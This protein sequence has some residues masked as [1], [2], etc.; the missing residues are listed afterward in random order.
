L[1][2]R[3][4]TV[5]AVALGAA[6]PGGGGRVPLGVDH[7]V[8][9][10]RCL[11]GAEEARGADERREEHGAGG[12][13]A[14]GAGHGARAREEQSTNGGV[15]SSERTP[16]DTAAVPRRNGR[17]GSLHHPSSLSGIAFKPSRSPSPRCAERSE[18]P[19]PPAQMARKG[20]WG[21]TS[22]GG[23]VV[24]ARIYTVDKGRGKQ[25]RLAFLHGCLIDASA[26]LWPSGI[27][28]VFSL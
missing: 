6:V 1:S 5:A 9:R 8:R 20:Q 14:R 24:A 3:G 7:P 23:R 18:L 26:P 13:R 25:E 11:P 16:T 10:P 12:G 17:G 2:I 27:R 28:F 21:C 15:T 19:R 22:R 4:L